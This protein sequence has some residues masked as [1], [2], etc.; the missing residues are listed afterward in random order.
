MPCKAADT[1]AIEIAQVI[2]EAFEKI[3]AQKRQTDMEEAAQKVIA[4]LPEAIYLPPLPAKVP[5][6]RLLGVDE[7]AVML[8]CSVATVQNLMNKGELVYVLLDPNSTHRKVP[9]SWV[10]EYIHALPRY[11]GKVKEKEAVP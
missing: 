1:E 2:T 10:V 5:E 6:E 8:D 11:K 7:I 9:Y 3:A 4:Q